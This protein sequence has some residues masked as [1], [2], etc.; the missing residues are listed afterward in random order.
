WV[1]E[2]YNISAE[3][4]DFQKS[5][6]E[7]IKKNPI[8]CYKTD[9]QKILSLSNIMLIENMKPLFLSISQTVWDKICRRKSSPGLPL[10]V[11]NVALEYSSMANSF[12]PLSDIQDAWCNNF[13][14]IT[15]LTDRDKDKFCQT[16][17]IFRNFLLLNAK[18][19]KT[20]NEDTFVHQ[21]L[22]DLLEE[23]FRD[24]MFDLIWA[25]SES[26]VSRNRRS[27]SSSDKENFRGEKPD[28]KIMT[29]TKEEILFGEVKTKYSL[30]LLVNKDLVKLSNF[31]AGALD[32]LVK[33]YGNKIGLTSFG[34]WIC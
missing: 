11:N 24:S 29:N 34:I 13:S 14:K 19:V 21:T 22:H 30:S 33:K 5:T 15:G 20:N 16:Q 28:F 18:S 4:R 6:I 9:I 10:E 8:L 1:Y 26:F 31:Q 3:F 32:E 27:N 17:I 12:T 7:Q 2:N 25:N 23:I